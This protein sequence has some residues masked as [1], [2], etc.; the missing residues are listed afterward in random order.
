MPVDFRKN[1]LPSE[2]GDSDAYNQLQMRRS[3]TDR[4][5]RIPRL[6]NGLSQTLLRVLIVDP[7]RAAADTTAMLVGTWG[8]DVRR[9]YDGNAGLAL[10]IEYQPDVLILE[11][12][13]PGLSG[14]ELA[15]QARREICAKDCLIVAVT[16]H[17][18]VCRRQ[19]SEADIDLVLIKP[20]D[21]PVLETLL[22]LE[23]DHVRSRNDTASFSVLAKAFRF[24]KQELPN[25]IKRPDRDLFGDPTL[26][27]GGE[28]C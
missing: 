22:M 7:H 3:I 6:I 18:E 12:F 16:G 14:L 10:A 9:A 26:T 24:A 15:R 2:F 13:M 20:L 19:C 21:P 1:R 11:A 28:T 4:E 25:L 17:A 23:S 5:G 8:H 27:G